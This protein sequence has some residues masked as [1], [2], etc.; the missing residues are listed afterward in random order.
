MRACSSLFMTFIPPLSSSS[1]IACPPQVFP[2]GLQIYAI[3]TFCG[4]VPGPT[5]PTASWASPIPNWIFCNSDSTFPARLLCA[6]VSVCVLVS[7]FPNFQSRLNPGVEQQQQKNGHTPSP[8]PQTP[9]W[10]MLLV[11]SYVPT[12]TIETILCVCLWADANKA[13]PHGFSPVAAAAARSG[14]TGKLWL[15]SAGT[16]GA[17]EHFRI[18]KN[19]HVG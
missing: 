15:I 6:C 13:Q 16:R 5:R 3:E 11:Y 14:P 10:N 4:T 12:Y 19:T 8:A 9:F 2:F 17:L 1:D 7:I 18:R